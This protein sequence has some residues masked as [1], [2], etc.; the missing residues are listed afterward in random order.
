[1]GRIFHQ[2]IEA[3]VDALPPEQRKEGIVPSSTGGDDV[4][5]FFNPLRI[6][7]V[8]GA[9]FR[10]V[11]QGFAQAR[12]ALKGL[13]QDDKL[14]KVGLGVG[15]LISPYKSHA[16]RQLEIAH[17]AE[18]QAKRLCRER[19]GPRSAAQLILLSGQDE[20]H[21][22]RGLEPPLSLDHEREGSWT[23]LMHRAK[24]LTRVP[25]SQRSAMRQARRQ[26]QGEE[27]VLENL[28]C[29]QLARTPAWQ[30]YFE[31]IRVDWR[32]RGEVV[33]HMPTERTYA[34]AQLLGKDRKAEASA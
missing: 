12:R 22:E 24:A 13:G 14:G 34:L 26:L 23:H 33:A 9:L 10:T 18:R 2:A 32:D 15:V 31:D 27:R 5:L 6:E 17:E 30:R 11:D 4:R 3:I 29:A 1:V 8:V 19:G 20:V 7:D 25:S 21:D 16:L 28:F